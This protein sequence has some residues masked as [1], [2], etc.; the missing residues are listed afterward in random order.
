M[1]FG[2]VSSRTESHN[3]R[4]HGRVFNGLRPTLPC[5][6]ILDRQA[7]I[8]GGDLRAR[9]EPIRSMNRHHWPQE[10]SASILYL[11]APFDGLA[12]D[13][14]DRERTHRGGFVSC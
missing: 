13:I 7:R 2:F 14:L 4:R 1:V 11:E 9:N 8:I 6:G 5:A 10:L 12:L 3:A